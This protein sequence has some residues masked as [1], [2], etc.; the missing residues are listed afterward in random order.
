MRSSFVLARPI[1]KMTIDYLIHVGKVLSG[2]TVNGEDD[3][4][5]EMGKGEML[6]SIMQT[7]DMSEEELT[8]NT[9]RSI[10]ST[11][12]QLIGAKYP[13]QRV[14]Y[15]NVKKEHIKAVVG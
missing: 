8:A 13:G 12:R 5:E 6:E 14:I 10:L 1:D 9:G 11:A 2:G 4:D 15:A 3:Y 7:L